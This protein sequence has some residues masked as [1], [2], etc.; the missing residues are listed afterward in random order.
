[1]AGD[2]RQAVPGYE[3]VMASDDHLLDSLTMS[4]ASPG[5]VVVIAESWK[6]LYCR[7]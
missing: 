4:F 5:S 7:N 6:F 1:M 3:S 2:L